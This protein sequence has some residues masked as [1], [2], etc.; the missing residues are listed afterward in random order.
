MNPI[1]LD[2]LIHGIP[3]HEDE[4][5]TANSALSPIHGDKKSDRMYYSKDD[6]KIYA[7]D[8]KD[9]HDEVTDQHHDG[10]GLLAKNFMSL[11]IR[12][13][14]SMFTNARLIINGKKYK[15]YVKPVRN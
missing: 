4:D 6:T 9:S 3:Y 13:R 5:T 12:D 1:D 14:N 15:L 11:L 10:K 2:F 8:D 7:T